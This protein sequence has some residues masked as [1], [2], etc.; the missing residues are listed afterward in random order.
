MAKRFTDALQGLQDMLRAA[1]K[2]T[3]AQTIR[4][5]PDYQGM[6]DSRQRDDFLQVI[7]TAEDSGAISASYHHDRTHPAPLT[8]VTLR[9]IDRLA[10]F[11]GVETAASKT[12]QSRTRLSS[13]LVDL[14]LWIVECVETTLQHWETNRPGPLGVRCHDTDSLITVLYLLSALEKQEHLGLDMRTFS[15]R[16]CGDSKAVEALRGPVIAAWRQ[17][18]E[19]P[20]DPDEALTAIGLEKFP[21]PVLVQGCF[22]HPVI[23]TVQAVPY[24]GFP[25]DM[26]TSGLRALPPPAYVLTIENFASFNRYVREIEDQGLI[27]YTNGFPSRTTRA[28][29]ARLDETLPATCPFYHWGDVDQG[30]LRILQT[31]QRSIKRTLLPHAMPLESPHWA[32]CIEDIAKWI[33][34]ASSCPHEQEQDDPC[35]PLAAP[36]NT[37]AR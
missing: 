31:L 23:G 7:R 24:L 5:V 25:L 8:S 34:T 2:P 35:S 30:G 11:L 3:P 10:R 15:R 17:R 33:A 4:F 21:H 29:L 9:D 32:S 13:H 19:L 12:R 18:E 36:Y 26:I 14:P 1:E 20:A 27:I 16:A 28:L 6:K 37:H 22:D